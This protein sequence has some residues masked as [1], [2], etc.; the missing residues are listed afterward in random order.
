[1]ENVKCLK[2]AFATREEAQN[3]LHEI[4]REAN[5]TKSKD[6]PK[7]AYLCDNCNKFH[8]TKVTKK[9]NEFKT[10]KNLRTKAREF[11][12]LKRE[13]EFWERKFGV[14]ID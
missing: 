11:A 6:F 7:R 3:R 14:K 4:Q 5:K 1:M 13:T 2:T 12:F 9:Q 10:D 8:L